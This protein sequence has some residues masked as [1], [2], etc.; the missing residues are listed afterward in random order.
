[1]IAATRTGRPAGERVN[2]Y[3]PWGQ[4]FADQPGSAGFL[5]VLRGSC[6]LLR[7]STPPVQLGPGDVVFSPHG[8]GY[9]MADNPATPLASPETSRSREGHEA[10]PP[11]ERADTASTVTLCG[12]YHLDPSRTHPLLRELPGVIHLPARL[13]AHPELWSAVEILA[14]EIDSTRLG[15]DAVMPLALDMLLL[16]IL[17]AWFEDR[18]QGG[19]DVG[20]AG[21]LADPAVRSALNAIHRAPARQWTVQELAE[22]ARLSRATFSRRFATLTGQ[23]PLKYLTWWRMTIAA[24]QLRDTGAS[25]GEVASHAGYTSEFAFA[26]A[27]KRHF[28]IAPGRYRSQARALPAEAGHALS[29]GP[30]DTPTPR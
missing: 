25:L 18:H 19:A 28:T 13:G 24:G 17:R 2:W 14:A 12:G 4:R 16:Y 5:V 3:A 10:P 22:Q 6:W 11:G 15:A 30:P 7:E 23:P 21:A 29:T 26:H 27:F 8:D 1:M 9:A 20:W